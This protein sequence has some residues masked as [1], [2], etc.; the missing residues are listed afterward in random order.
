M[1]GYFQALLDFVGQHPHLAL[2]LAFLVAMAEALPIIGLFVPSTV[3][4]AG[5]GGLAGIGQ[6]GFWPLFAA[7]TL[8]ATAGDAVGYWFGRV[9]HE[10]LATV[11][12]ISRYPGLLDSGKRYFARH[13]GKSVMIGRFIPGIKSVVPAIA[14]M[15]GMSSIRFTVLNVTSAAVWTAAHILPGYSAGVVF[16]IAGTVSKRLAILLA[17]AV[18]VLLLAVW[19]THQAVRFGV[20]TL[21]RL[22]AAL[23]GWASAREGNLASAVLRLVAPDHT[24]FRLLAILLALFGGA[25]IGFVTIAED[26]V[27]GEPGLQFDAS[28]SQFLQGL[29]T[30]WGD[31]IMIRATMLGDASV[32]IAVVSA[33]AAVLV[34]ARRFRLAIA[35]VATLAVASVVAKGLK[36]AIRAPRP[37]EMFSG[38][39]AFS[40][41]SGHAISAATLYGA[42]GLIVLLGAPGRPGRIFVALLACLVGVIAFSR[43]YLSA[44]W[45]SDVAA[46]VLFG[47]AATSGLALVFRRYPVSPAA[48]GGVVAA[49]AV[50]LGLA[51]GWHIRQDF[52]A[53]EVIYAPPPPP[54][55]VLAQ[56]VRQ[57]GWR[58]LPSAR[59]DLDGETEEPLVLLW[60]GDPAQ[61][62][63]ALRDRGWRPPPDWSLTALNAFAVPGATAADL[64]ALPSLHNGR[65]QI[66]TAVLPDDPGGRYVLRAWRIESRDAS[67]PLQILAASIIRET[68]TAPL[69]MLSLPMRTEEKHCDGPSLLLKLPGA[70]EVGPERLGA[71][72]ACGGRLVIAGEKLSGAN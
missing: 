25:I 10:R 44:H 67:G 27:T 34:L 43:V 54:A 31:Q 33:V 14:G 71:D 15:T 20:R 9:Y 4:L 38:A 13:G 45:P 58:D 49:A 51:G 40:F 65:R 68:I 64:P 69:G 32:T 11:W 6:V 55:I 1:I 48:A 28:A 61:L 42:L 47:A 56:S 29:R 18:V 39:E 26:V 35:V 19:L 66:M 37:A 59:I 52:S 63:A 8:G 22:Q 70:V 30:H 2:A 36:L 5:L 24:D 62:A 72:G 50:A 57:G 17:I 41:P 53:M 7:T 21:P 60:E 46:G 12:P 23:T 16:A 3:V